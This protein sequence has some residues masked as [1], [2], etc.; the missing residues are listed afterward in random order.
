[1][2]FR[3]QPE[4]TTEMANNHDTALA[5]VV[6]AMLLPL[7]YNGGSYHSCL[8]NSVSPFH[9]SSSLKQP[10]LCKALTDQRTSWIVAKA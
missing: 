1:M 10:E 2:S 5:A 7:I 4:P 8:E 6:H 9:V 3:P